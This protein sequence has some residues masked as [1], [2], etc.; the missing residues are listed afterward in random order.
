L[1][2]KTKASHSRARHFAAEGNGGTFS[3][4][5]FGGLDAPKELMGIEVRI[6]PYEPSDADEIYDAAIE[7]VRE[8]EPWMP[9]C[10]S[11]YQRDDAVAWIQATVAGRGSKTMYD[12]AI[13]ADG[14]YVGGC[15]INHIN[16]MDRVA[17]LGYW[18]RTTATRRGV[19]TMAAREVI[20]WSFA[21]TDLN[22]IEIVAACENIASQRVAEKLGADRD[23]VLRKRTLVN[24][25]PADAILY[26]VIRPD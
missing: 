22:R 26:S 9:W 2:L 21:K 13:I 3:T 16:W 8:I 14:R 11:K 7:S 18:V 25:R 10:H 19:A 1:P 15:G 6:R 4:A 23:A 12:F 24:G 20:N 17:N 5:S